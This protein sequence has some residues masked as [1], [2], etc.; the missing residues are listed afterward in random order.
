MAWKWKWT[1]GQL[2]KLKIVKEIIA[3]LADYLPLTLRQIHYQMVSKGYYENTESQYIMLSSNVKHARFDDLIGWDVIEDRSRIFHDLTGW[4]D[5]KI[6]TAAY[7]ESFSEAYKR[8]LLQSQDKY[9]ELWIEK[10]AL[11]SLFV[12]IAEPYTIPVVASRGFNSVSF[13][14]DFRNR[15]TP[16]IQNGKEAVMLYFGDFDPS[17]LA[18]LPAIERNLKMHLGV[19]NLRCRM[20]AL[21]Q[22]N[23]IE[24]KLPHNPKALKKKDKRA[25][26]HTE[27][28]GELAVE[29]DALPPK[30]LEQKIHNA[31]HKEINLKTFKAEK[32][33]Q[34]R[35]FNK[36]KEI[37]NSITNVVNLD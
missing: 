28:Y 25:K 7:F 11:S 37:A 4:Q 32:A 15:A 27:L 13:Q 5:Y 19:S 21:T 9:I 16:H 1:K 3:E 30:I 18:V 33:Y 17:G 10:D 14:N 6:Y 31:I 34:Q 8:D 36:L 12:R 20:V 2:N 24:Y 29:L 26:R 35:D 22:Q 23:I